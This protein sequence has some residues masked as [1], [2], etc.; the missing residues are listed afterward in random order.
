MRRALGPILFGIVVFALTLG[1]GLVWTA[2]PGSDAAYQ[3]AAERIRAARQEDARVLRFSDL[4]GLG[5]LPPELG[6]MTEV[7]Q[8][9]LRGTVISDISVLAGME[10]LRSLSLRGTLVEDLTPLAGLPRLD[11]LDVSQSWVHDLS[12]LVDLPALRRLDIGGTWIESLAPLRRVETLGWLNLHRA[13]ASD[14]SKDHLEAL[15]MAGVTVNNGRV[16]SQ[17][18]RPGMI[19]RLRLRYQRLSRRVSLGFAHSGG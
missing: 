15:A 16:V 19:D 3:A 11:I 1:G 17:D 8:L 7:I 14:G 2:R 5:A 10:G 13:I 12:P 18:T 6:E 9:D 4:G